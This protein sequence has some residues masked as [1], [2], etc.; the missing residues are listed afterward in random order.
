MTAAGAWQPDPIGEASWRWWDGSAWGPQTGP[1]R[2]IPEFQPIAT[3][4]GRS[5]LL[6]QDHPSGTDVLEC[7]G[8]PLGT[9]HTPFMGEI[10]MECATGAW[11]FDREGIVHGAARV[12]VQ[13]SNQEIGRFDWDGIGTGTDGLLRFTDGR[14]FRLTRA[15]Q[16]AQEGVASPADYDPAH[17][18][19]VWYGPDRQPISTVRL[20][21]R[22]YTKKIFGKEIRYTKSSTGK[23]GQDIFTDLHA[24]AATVRELPLLTTLGT[25]LIWWTTTQ[26]EAMQRRR[27]FH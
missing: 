17:S 10:S 4:V 20:A 2:Q 14:W 15:K 8:Q 11:L 3:A 6:N 25:F 22:Y 12:I 21:A 1:A 5:V 13:P 18:I 24:H 9:M 26:R 19:W 27:N 23:T 7:E 16:L